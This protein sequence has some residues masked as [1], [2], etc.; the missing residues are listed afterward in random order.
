MKMENLRNITILLS[1]LAISVLSVTVP[2]VQAYTYHW[3]RSTNR[4]AYGRNFPY[5]YV[6]YST[7]Y[8]YYVQDT[9]GNLEAQTQTLQAQVQASQSERDQA[10]AQAQQ[11][12]AQID[13]LNQ[14]VSDLNNQINNVNSQYT[15]QISTMQNSNQAL[16]S[17]V[18]D[19]QNSNQALQGN[20]D[21]LRT[22]NNIMLIVLAIL[23]A[24]FVGF[25]LTKRGSNANYYRPKPVT[26]QSPPGGPGS[27]G[28]DVEIVN[29]DNE[30]EI[31][32]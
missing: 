32:N 21:A 13:S 30:V 14:Q 11:L 26:Y 12:S 31:L 19:L 18:S 10:V 24:C 20:L 23:G 8:Y 4:Y 28:V 17:Q 9:I 25:L 29:N 1:I 3:Y 5:R 7:P 15:S 27:V 22:Q 2:S 6:F 16:Q